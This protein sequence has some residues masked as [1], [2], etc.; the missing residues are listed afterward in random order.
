MSDQSSDAEWG[1]KITVTIYMSDDA[2]EV[3]KVLDCID[4]QLLLPPSVEFMRAKVELGSERTYRPRD[5]DA[6]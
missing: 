6:S 4:A 1:H 5:A 2:L 3:Q